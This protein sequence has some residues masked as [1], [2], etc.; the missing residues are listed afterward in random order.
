[1]E[2]NPLHSRDLNH[3]VPALFN[4]ILDFLTDDSHQIAP[5]EQVFKG[6]TPSKGIVGVAG[7]EEEAKLAL[8]WQ[9]MSE[10]V[11]IYSEGS[12]SQD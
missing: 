6:V 12:P 8:R 9:T 7:K 2:Q 11:R 10:Q 1:M 3:G 4:E 5:E